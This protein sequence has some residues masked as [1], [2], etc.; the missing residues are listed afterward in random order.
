MSLSKL[1][2]I[3]ASDLIEPKSNSYYNI[4]RCEKELLKLSNDEL[5]YQHYFDKLDSVRHSNWREIFPELVK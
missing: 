3:L 2:K 4:A 1:K 5:D